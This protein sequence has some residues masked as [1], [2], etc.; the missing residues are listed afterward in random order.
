MHNTAITNITIIICIA[1]HGDDNV[2]DSDNNVG[3]DGDD[4]GDW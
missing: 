4:D 1:Y 3:D 2:D